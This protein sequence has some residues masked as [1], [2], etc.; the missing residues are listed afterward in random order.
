MDEHWC[1]LERLIRCVQGDTEALVHL[2]IDWEIDDD[3]DEP[4]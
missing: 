1:D 2:D 4:N 3:I